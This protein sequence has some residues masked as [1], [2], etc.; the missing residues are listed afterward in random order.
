MPKLALTANDMTAAAIG[1][2]VGSGANDLTFEFFSGSVSLGTIDDT[3]DSFV[4]GST[5]ST[6]PV[7]VSV[8]ITNNTAG[9]ISL[10]VDYY[11]DVTIDTVNYRLHFPEETVPKSSSLTYYFDKQ[12]IPFTDSD[13]LFP[14]VDIHQVENTPEIIDNQDEEISSYLVVDDIVNKVD[15]VETYQ[16]R[17][18]INTFSVEHIIDRLPGISVLQDIGHILTTIV[19]GATWVLKTATT[20]SWRLK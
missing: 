3:A 11:I 1:S 20:I 7:T 4:D 14:A 6:K 15:S 17:E 13:L 12:G 18:V 19:R 2:T 8:T 9:D 5:N 16:F 10:G